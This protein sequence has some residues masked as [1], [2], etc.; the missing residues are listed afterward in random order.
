MYLILL[1][2]AVH[3]HGRGT[4]LGTCLVYAPCVVAFVACVNA[5]EFSVMYLILLNSVVHGHGQGTCLSTYLVLEPCVVCREFAAAVNVSI[6]QLCIG[7]EEASALV[8][9]LCS[10]CV[11]LVLWVCSMCQCLIM[12][13][14]HGNGRGMRLGTCLLYAACVVAIVACVIGDGLRCLKSLHVNKNTLVWYETTILCYKQPPTI[15]LI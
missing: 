4:R 12:L 2:S 11:R 8:S 5:D 14:V 1:K 6:C 7:M 10:S 3:R 13:V 15:T 9:A